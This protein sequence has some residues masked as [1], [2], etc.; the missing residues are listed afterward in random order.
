MLSFYKIIQIIG[1]IADWTKKA[2]D[3]NKITLQEAVGLA[4]RI[5]PVLGVDLDID[6]PLPIDN[7]PEIKTKE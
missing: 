3:D 6:L 7:K 4:E 2:L 5:A 1:I